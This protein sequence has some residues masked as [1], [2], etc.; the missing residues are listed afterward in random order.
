MKNKDKWTTLTH[1]GPIFPAEYNYKGFNI[2][3]GESELVFG[4]EVEEMIYE[5]SK[6][7]ETEYVKDKVFQKNFYKDLKKKMLPHGLELIEGYKFP[8]DWDFR[9]V[10]A[11]IQK[12]KESKKN[13]TKEDRKF[14]KDEREK[15]KAEF[16]VAMLDGKS[17]QLGNYTVEPP[18]I[19]MGRGK[20]P[21]RG[22]WKPRIYPGDVTLNLSKNIRVPVTNDGTKWKAVIEN[23]NALWT[24]MW[25][26]KLTNSQKRVLFSVNSFV[27]QNNDRKKFEKAIELSKNIDK[28]NDFIE[29]KLT[30]RDKLTRELATIGHMI[31]KLSI[32]VGDEKGSD[33]ADT[34]GAT[35]LR[36]EHVKIDNTTVHFN[37]LGKDSI[38]YK[39]TVED[40]NINAVRNLKEFLKDKKK[41]DRIFENIT[42]KDVNDFFKIVMPGLSAKQFRT[43]SGSTLLANALA[44][45]KIKKDLK[46]GKKL[47][48]FTEANLDVA[49]KLNHQSAV[50][51]AYEK[52]LKN[53]KLK[54]KEI[55]PTLKT[56]KI[57]ADKEIKLAEEKRKERVAYANSKWSGQRKSDAIKRARKTYNNTKERWTKRVDR[58][59]ERIDNYKTK[60]NIK[61]KTKG[62]A[63]GTSKGSY[64][65]PKI[66]ISWCKDNDV[67]VKRIYSK[68]Y[69]EKFS[70]A[71]DVDRDYYKRYPNV[72]S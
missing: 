29:K 3:I 37:F 17:V 11:D 35:S 6:K 44:K 66:A 65:S 5:W 42:S 51:E 61:E 38:E 58:L 18:G 64:A 28:V 55:K 48:F 9:E 1:Q 46:P 8:E 20:H 7:L 4:K 23:K 13:K 19:F 68:T 43:M 49:I 60:I 31:S 57:E 26:E 40:F 71:L 41:G 12:I 2:Y 36:F 21:L 47:E 30:S 59:T 16:G 70:W 22:R 53:M 27:R 69:L 54:L 34:V 32:R 39:N 62:V 50:S 14:E 67:D 15:R 10:W 52:S 72:D 25:Y 24:C 63:L 45:T 33:T 56:L